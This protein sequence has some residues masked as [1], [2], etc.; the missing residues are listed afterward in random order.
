MWKFERKRPPG[1][2]RRRC[3]GDINVDLSEGGWGRDLTQDMDGWRALVVMLM[4]F[5]VLLDAGFS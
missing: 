3:E 5:R 2:T 1:K 4:S